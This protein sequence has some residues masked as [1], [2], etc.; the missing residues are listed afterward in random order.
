MGKLFI[1]FPNLVLWQ[2][3]D[4]VCHAIVCPFFTYNWVDQAGD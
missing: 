1:N 2:S 3:V 4:E